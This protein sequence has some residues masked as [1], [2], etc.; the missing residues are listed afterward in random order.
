MA[1]FHLLILVLLSAF[2]AAAQGQPRDYAI[3]VDG[4]GYTADA[5]V[6]SFTVSNQ[7]GDA[8]AASEVFISEYQTGQV[9]TSAELP[10]LA[11]DESRNFSLPMPLAGLTA[12]NVSI[13]IQA[14][15]DEFE[16]EGSPIARN[17]TQLFL[18]NRADAG[19][20]GGDSAGSPG[21]SASAQNYDLYIPLVNLGFNFQDD[22]IEVN[23]RGYS[24][25]DLL[26]FAGM[27]LA[28]LFCLWLLSLIL[29]LIFRRPPKF[30]PWQPPYAV[31][32]WHDPNSA[33]G[34]RQAW[35]F[36]AQSSAI[37]A[38][39][40]P[41]QVTVIKRLLGRDGDIL[42]GWM[43]RAVRTAQYDIYGRI[44]RSEVVMS[45]KIN[46]QLNR[47]MR[48][49]PG[50][51]TV[52]LRKALT[53]VSKRLCKSALAAIEKQNRALPLAL[54]M[55]LDGLQ[56]EV[57]ILFELYQYRNSA[58]H[59]IDHW[60][61]ELGQTGARVPEHLTFTLNGQLPGEN[62]KEFKARLRDD[63]TNLLA[64]MLHHQQNGGAAD[65]EPEQTAKRAD[66]D[67]DPD[68]DQPV[69]SVGELLA[70]DEETD[71]H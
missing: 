54:D 43:V 55:R 34:R 68:P 5:A 27:T 59:L 47:I 46:Q 29:R 35:Q 56:G 20:S 33:L 36:H 58:W 39:G 17:N 21:S 13:Q 42:G 14:G 65:M 51:D 57:R 3:S 64:G 28:A 62:Y 9:V 31:N 61:P 48:R 70:S 7:G 18:I 16:L 38:A 4:V 67:P 49:A 1:R 11:A 32:N 23:G 69:P 50:L 6:I 26:I 22:G 44:S 53:P 30:E 12:D 60:E 63:M 45:R 2:A 8:L 24:Q 41:D 19:L 10:A 40:A 37:S 25:R 15:I 52:E 71:A 66:P